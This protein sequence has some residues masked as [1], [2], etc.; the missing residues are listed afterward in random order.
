MKINRMLQKTKEKIAGNEKGFTL[1]E[2]MI[3]MIISLIMLA[4]MVGLLLMGFQTFTSGRNLQSVTDASRRALPAI[5]REMKGLLHINDDECQAL[6]M[7]NPSTQDGIWNGIS[8]YSDIDNDDATATVSN[9]LVTEKVKIYYD[10]NTHTLMQKVTQP[11]GVE[12][13]GTTIC[14]YVNSVRFYYFPAGTAPGKVVRLDEAPANRYQGTS[15]N[16]MAGSIKVVVTMQNGTITR[17][18]EQTTFLRV[19]QRSVTGV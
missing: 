12:P 15:L 9:Y 7:V 5:D 2:L 16:N 4:G 18:F 11:G 10:A 19:L 8:F 17:T 6:Y 13:T 14:S 1:V 3:V